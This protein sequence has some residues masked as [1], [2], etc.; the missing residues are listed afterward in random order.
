MN[1]SNQK[2]GGPILLWLCLVL[3]VPRGAAQISVGPVGIGPITFDTLPPVQWFTR[4]IPGASSDITDAA[5]LDAH[6]QTN[7]DRFHNS[8]RDV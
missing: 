1:R 6:V 4:S 3:L 7:S 8:T 2:P 5:G